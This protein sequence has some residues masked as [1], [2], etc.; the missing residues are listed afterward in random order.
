MLAMRPHDDRAL[1]VP[2]YARMLDLARSS[3]TV[4]AR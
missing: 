1:L 3:V 2:L 4:A